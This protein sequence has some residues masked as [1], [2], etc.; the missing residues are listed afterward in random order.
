MRRATRI[1]FSAILLVSALSF[2]ACG[3]SF[4]NPPASVGEDYPSGGIPVSVAWPSDWLEGF[5]G[6]SDAV[7]GSIVGLRLEY[8]EDRWVWRVRSLDP[9]H[10]LLGESVTKPER[11]RESLIDAST[12]ALMKQHQ[13]TLSEAELAEV[14]VSYYAAAQRAGETYP[15]PRLIELQ[16]QIE[17]GR[18]VWRVTTYDTDTGVQSTTTV[19]AL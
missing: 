17:D 19:D 11:G 6:E 13:V 1:L 8:V 2:T 4:P 3:T 10:D 12:L 7:G 16:R 14:E 5:V 15:S 9:G 18:P